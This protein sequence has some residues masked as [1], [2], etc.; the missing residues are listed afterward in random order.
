L[1]SDQTRPDQQ[2]H[3]QTAVARLVSI[4]DPWAEGHHSVEF[5][6]GPIILSH[7]TRHGRELHSRPR[8]EFRNELLCMKKISPDFL[9]TIDYYFARPETPQISDTA[10]TTTS[11][12]A[13]H[14]L[15]AA[16][17]DLLNFHRGL[18]QGWHQERERERDIRSDIVVVAD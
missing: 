5:L 9:Q 7:A 6:S 1:W 13:A 8:K 15:T 14:E 16:H 17:T 4:E 12:L 2:P 11:V 18:L 10:T 3:H